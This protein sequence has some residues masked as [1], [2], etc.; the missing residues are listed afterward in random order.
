MVAEAH[1]S[2]LTVVALHGYAMDGIGGKVNSVKSVTDFP[3][4][5]VFLQHNS[6]SQVT[7]MNLGSVIEN[8]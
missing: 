7:D 5:D 6:K 2:S 3:V 8:D 1:R 4:I